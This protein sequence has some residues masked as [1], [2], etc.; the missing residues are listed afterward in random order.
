MQVPGDVMDMSG[1]AFAALIVGQ[2][3]AV[4][5]VHGK[6]ESREAPIVP[7]FPDHRARLIW[8]GGS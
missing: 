1:L 8:E 2:F 6:R 3:A 4:I 5:A 7:P